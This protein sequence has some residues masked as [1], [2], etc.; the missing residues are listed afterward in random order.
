M[1]EVILVILV[2]A[3][4]IYDNSLGWRW[5]FLVQIPLFLVSLALTQYYLR[6]VTPVRLF[7]DRHRSFFSLE[8]P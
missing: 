6:Y 2:S 4:Q 3:E 5:A 1:L 8:I 7:L